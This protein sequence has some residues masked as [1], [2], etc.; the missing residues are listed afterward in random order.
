MSVRR[1]GYDRWTATDAPGFALVGEGDF[2]PLRAPAVSEAPCS[3]MLC[4]QAVTVTDDVT[5]AAVTVHAE[6]LCLTRCRV[7]DW[8][9]FVAGI[10]ARSDAWL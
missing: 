8:A 6:P 7:S 4:D 5:G 2:V 9:K 1:N 10:A 3:P